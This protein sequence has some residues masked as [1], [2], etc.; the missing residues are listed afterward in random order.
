[1]AAA[2]AAA[3][4]QTARLDWLLFADHPTSRPSDRALG[5]VNELWPAAQKRLAG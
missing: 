4:R 2:A 5:R 3:N 1:M